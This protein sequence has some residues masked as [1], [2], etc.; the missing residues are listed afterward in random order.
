MDGDRLVASL[1]AALGAASGIPLALAQLDFAGAIDVF[2]IDHGDVRPG[3]LVVAAI[4]G[5][6]TSCVVAAAL[7]GVGLCLAGAPAA[8]TVLVAAAF[9]GFATALMLW[10]PVALAILT[11]AHLLDS[12]RLSSKG[13]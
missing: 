2:G 9:A 5:V 3:L 13:A 10:L 7:V 4:G 11:A 8:R 1:L 12:P 6:L